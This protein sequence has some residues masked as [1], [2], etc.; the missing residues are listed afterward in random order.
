MVN[1][2]RHFPA[3]FGSQTRKIR[4]PRKTQANFPNSFRVSHLVCYVKAGPQITFEGH[5]FAAMGLDVADQMKKA[6]HGQRAGSAFWPEGQ[7][8]N[9]LIRASGLWSSQDPCRAT[10]RLVLGGGA[11]FQA[12]GSTGQAQT[13]GRVR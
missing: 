7:P 4:H 3:I 13:G 9:G 10:W 12:H 1:F 5:R 11:A 8:L 2:C 6:G